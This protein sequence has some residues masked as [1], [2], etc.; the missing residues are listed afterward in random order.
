MSIITP[1][2]VTIAI[3]FMLMCFLVVLSFSFTIKA[4]VFAARTFG[5]CQPAYSINYSQQLNRYAL[6]LACIV[7]AGIAAIIYTY[8]QSHY[9]LMAIAL[10]LTSA[11]TA[12][13]FSSD[14]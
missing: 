3:L 12:N 7:I 1:A 8:V 11:Y 2:N 10:I 9:F 4:Y 6:K 14:S 5:F 13:E